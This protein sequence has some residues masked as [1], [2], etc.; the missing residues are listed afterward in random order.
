MRKFWLVL[1]S[2]IGVV[3]ALAGISQQ[4]QSAARSENSNS[5][6][7]I[8][9]AWASP[10]ELPE[11]EDCSDRNFVNVQST[12]WSCPIFPIYADSFGSIYYC[13]HYETS[14]C[15]D[16]PQADLIFGDYDW[17]Y[18]G[19]GFP[20]CVGGSSFRENEESPY[21]GLPNYVAEN[22]LHTWTAENTTL[23]G[24]VFG[25]SCIPGGPARNSCQVTKDYDNHFLEAKVQDEMVYAKILQLRVS[26]KIAV[27]N[28]AG[29][30]PAKDPTSEVFYVA[31]QTG[32]SFGKP[33][34]A[35]DVVE[36]GPHAFHCIAEV[37]PENPH[38][39]LVLLKKRE[40]TK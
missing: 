25:E 18:A 39:V 2:A 34:T 36:R 32:E 26:R 30:D 5:A 6:I 20:H 22:Y 1:V 12:R 27:G 38:R 11:C 10:G 24:Q 7:S 29:D 19:C 13:D 16:S 33:V 28:L 23:A 9:P 35:V 8:Q 14:N 40:N 37:S 31:F 4:S 15:S 17:P 3:G 21:P